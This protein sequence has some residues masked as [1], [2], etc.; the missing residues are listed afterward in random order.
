MASAGATMMVAVSSNCGSGC[1]APVMSIALVVMT[2]ALTIV[3]VCCGGNV[4]CPSA[5]IWSG[6]GLQFFFSSVMANVISTWGKVMVPLAVSITAWWFLM[7]FSPIMGND[8]FDS[9][10]KVSVNVY[11]PILN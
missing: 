10:T 8:V 1:T 2:I 5:M 4:W 3:V 11:V 6:L 7:K 9:M